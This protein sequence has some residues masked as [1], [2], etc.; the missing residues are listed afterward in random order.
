M[1][2]ARPLTLQENLAAWL[3]EHLPRIDS[4]KVAHAPGAGRG[5]RLPQPDG[6]EVA[7]VTHGDAVELLFASADGA[8]ADGY[9]LTAGTAMHLAYWLVGWWAWRCWFGAR[10]ALWRW[11][12]RAR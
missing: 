7:L 2:S 4:H 9:T 8:G 1:E 6:S 10:T 11:A 12:L 3:V 5:L